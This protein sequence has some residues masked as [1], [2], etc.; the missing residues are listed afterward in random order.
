MRKVVTQHNVIADI[1]RLIGLKGPGIRRC[2]AAKSWV[3]LSRIPI[4]T[5]S[6]A[7]EVKVTEFVRDHLTCPC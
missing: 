4:S 2:T 3:Y 5:S 7:V 6:L 1:L